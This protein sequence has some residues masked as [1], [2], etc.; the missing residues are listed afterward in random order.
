MKN[1]QVVFENTTDRMA[2]IGLHNEYLNFPTVSF[3][4]TEW[5][6]DLDWDDPRDNGRPMISVTDIADEFEFSE[7]R[8]IGGWS[9]YHDLLSRFS[10]LKCVPG[11]T[12]NLVRFTSGDNTGL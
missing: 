10:C 2:F 11:D 1:Y 6:G 7:F 5:N 12:R 4:V 8:E 9:K 3:E